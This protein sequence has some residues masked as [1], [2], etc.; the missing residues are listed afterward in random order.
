VRDASKRHRLAA[1]V[2][3]ALLVLLVIGSAAFGGIGKP[4]LPDGAVAFVDD[5]P[6]FECVIDGKTT[7]CDGAVTDAEFDDSLAQA[8][9]N[10]NLPEPP[11]ESDPQFEQVKE[12]A[13]ANA[14]QIRWVRGEAAE[15]GIEVDDR[16]VDVAFEQIVRDQLGGEK[17]LQKFLKEAPYT[18][19]EIREVA[20][21]NAVAEQVQTELVGEGPPEVPDDL[22]EDFYEQNRDQ[23]TQ[24][25][26]RDVREI[27]NEDEAAVEDARAALEED[28]SDENW[29]KV[30]KEFSSAPSK[31][32]GGLREAVV[33]GQDDPA[34]EE[35][36]FSAP[37]GELVGPFETEAGFYLIQV[38][39]TTPEEVTPLEETREQI[40][41]QLGQGIQQ[42]EQSRVIQSFSAEWR[43]RTTCAED[44]EIQL[45]GNADPAPDTC[46]SDDPAEREGADP[47]LLEQGC[48]AP[49]A[50][51][52]VALPGTNTGI[53][54][55]PPQI[56]PQG[57]IKAPEESA[58]G[59]LPPG[60]QGLPPGAAPPQGAPPAGAPPQGAPPQGA[61][62]QGGAPAPPPGG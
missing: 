17:Q 36:I 19:E 3:G 45:C 60:L 41:A 10:L 20:A 32:D 6:E 53:P 54:G 52:P 43:A 42:D 40:E 46:P 31:K 49:V 8:A 9:F 23:F 16:E 27:V 18:E 58:P 44:F 48:E 21:L 5:V 61:P 14:I 7:Q 33:E 11:P 1:A 12:S 4:G 59:G 13:L 35:E 56:L 2:L 50:P 55:S 39:A 22:V 47:A 26:S 25:Q 57:P 51:R 38:V 29:E 15:R 37:E 30:A 62:P 34:L 28:D 24:P